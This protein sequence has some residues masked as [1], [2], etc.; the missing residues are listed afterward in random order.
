MIDVSAGC[1]MARSRVPVRAA[2][3]AARRAHVDR[4]RCGLDGVPP[5]ASGL[6]WWWWLRQTGWRVH[7]RVRGGSAASRA[8]RRA[9]AADGGFGGGR[10][11]SERWWWR[12]RDPDLVED[13][14]PVHERRHRRG[15]CGWH[16]LPFGDAGKAAGRLGRR[17]FLLEAPTCLL[18]GTR[19]SPRTAAVVAVTARASATGESH[20]A[21]TVG[22]TR[23]KRCPVAARQRR[24][25]HRLR[26]QGRRWHSPPAT[27]TSAPVVAA[28]PSAGS[29]STHRR[30]GSP[31]SA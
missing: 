11:G 7:H 18:A 4:L 15:R 25:W 2:S 22:S 21:R 9:R 24:R 12:W 30:P 6:G 1:A 8:D 3:R 13:D 23:R 5:A 16:R 14:D 26:R 10:G 20:T 17:G 28:V 27:P 19:C 31:C 29:G